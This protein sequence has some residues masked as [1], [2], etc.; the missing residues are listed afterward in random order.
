MLAEGSHRHWTKNWL[1]R[2]LKKNSGLHSSHTSAGEC[3]SS[4]EKNKPLLHLSGLGYIPPEPLYKRPWDT[5]YP[6]RQFYRYSNIISHIISE[7]KL[8]E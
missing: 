2:I 1:L 5:Q 6:I 3:I 7:Q 4:S 8:K